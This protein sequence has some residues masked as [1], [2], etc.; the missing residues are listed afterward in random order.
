MTRIRH[1]PRVGVS[2]LH[3]AFR[4]D[5]PHMWLQDRP[6]SLLVPAEFQVTGCRRVFGP[7]SCDSARGGDPSLA[8]F[9]DGLAAAETQAM[10]VALH[11][12]GGPRVG[13]REGPVGLGKKK[14]KM[15][16]DRGLLMDGFRRPFWASATLLPGVWPEREAAVRQFRAIDLAPVAAAE[17]EGW[18]G[19]GGRLQLVRDGAAPRN[20]TPSWGSPSRLPRGMFARGRHGFSGFEV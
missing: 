13:T 11:G 4:R 7:S 20:C 1:A 8:R 12:T 15:R 16:C 10:F 2:K 9:R 18:G 17:G 5:S 14:K 19:T 3:W 6:R